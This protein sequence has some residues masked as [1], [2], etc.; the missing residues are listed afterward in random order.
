VAN[1]SREASVRL[2]LDNGQYVV[3]IRQAGDATEKEQKKASKAAQM[4]GAGLSR[5][6]DQA[7]AVGEHIKR[8]A[9]LAVTFGG[10]FSFG[11]ALHSVVAL[12]TSYKNLA[13]AIRAGTGQQTSFRQLMHD[14]NA[15]ATRWGRSNDEV[16]QS[17]RAL[18][19]EVGDVNFAKAG[20]EQVAKAATATGASMQSLTGIAGVLNEKFNVTAE[21]L[22][23]AL[24]T[25]VSLGNR[26]GASI[27]DMGEK[28]GILGAAARQAG[29]EG[30]N[31]LGQV[32]G[33]LNVADNATGS[34]KKSLAAV[35]GLLET[36]GDP[37]KAKKLEK[38]LGISL[39]DAKGST[40]ADALQRIMSKTGGKREAL[41]KVFGGEQAKLMIE[42]G[43][44][45]SKAFDST[46]GDIKTR[47]KAATDAFN[48][49]LAE[50][51]KS[52]LTAADL[53]A[54]AKQRLEDPQRK[55]QA[56]LNKLEEAMGSPE[57]IDALNKLAQQLPALA[58]V[59]SK[60]IGWVAQNPGLAAGGAAGAMVGKAF[61]GGALEKA[62]GSFAE[63]A[64]GGA[65]A[66]TAGGRFAAAAFGPAVIGV[67]ALA[68]GMAIG[69]A[70]QDAIE[71]KRAA[72]RKDAATALQKDIDEAQGMS[73]TAAVE[74]FGE[75]GRR[76]KRGDLTNEE[77]LTLAVQ[78]AK[79]DSDA[80]EVGR[81]MSGK[82]SREAEVKAM[83]VDLGPSDAP[84]S[85]LGQERLRRAGMIGGEGATP[86]V[87][88]GGL[89]MPA[90]GF[91]PAAGGPSEVKIENH[92]D[93][94]SAL[95]S[96]LRQG[97]LK[98]ELVNPP[99]SSSGRGAPVIAPPRP[100]GG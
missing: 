75:R 31:G 90:G 88:V 78:D 48:A 61:L 14:G 35:T 23:D 95:A 69:N 85:A 86:I 37:E 70:V 100:G 84:I 65:A 15:I 6:G 80:V 4:W 9:S 51:G 49:A 81:S 42:L 40:R 71:A 27:E 68:I 45:Y 11:A 18:Y 47:T 28:L 7:K 87:P 92:K 34:F 76:L 77:R 5:V 2:V 89:S 38:S 54:Q 62:G 33:L 50:A 26:G 73:E 53:D 3:A 59:I 56:A 43:R 1:N 52:Q 94:A 8:A 16:A 91:A 64:F 67:A 30:K 21:Q 12:E 57:I 24:A 39:R 83:G 58:N 29:I 63:K 74:K 55:L 66:T 32:V 97:T 46:A 36:L 10:A 17:V 79:T 44:T 72:K 13:F 19:D 82:F 41:E 20:A 98:V 96:S 22:P 99:G 60:V 93:L 25:V